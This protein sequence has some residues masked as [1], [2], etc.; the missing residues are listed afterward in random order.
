M[1]IL[2]ALMD[3]KIIEKK[4]CTH[5]SHLKRGSAPFTKLYVKHEFKYQQIQNSNSFCLNCKLYRLINIL[6]DNL[7]TLTEKD[8]SRLASFARYNV[9]SLQNNIDSSQPIHRYY[10]TNIENTMIQSNAN[11]RT[12]TQFSFLEHMLKFKHILT[13]KCILLCFTPRTIDL[14]VTI[15]NA[16]Q[17]ILIMIDK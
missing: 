5:C 16:I 3:S 6:A 1:F 7:L 11:I 15:L 8:Q 4:N 9:Y 2:N 12:Y 13:K 10:S 14:I 17:K